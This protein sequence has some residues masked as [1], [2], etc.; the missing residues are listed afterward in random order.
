MCFMTPNRLR[1]GKASTIWVVVRGPRLK[2]SRIARLV[3][4]DN[5]FHTGSSSSASTLAPLPLRLRGAIFSDSIQHVFPAGTHAF[6]V[7]RIDEADRAMTEVHMGSSWALFELHFD[8]VQR[9]VGH[10]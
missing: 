1:C 4:S 10:K 2:R 6:F 8:M 5:A 7:S 3:L 9:R